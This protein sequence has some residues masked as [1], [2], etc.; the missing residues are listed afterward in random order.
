MVREETAFK[1]GEWQRLRNGDGNEGQ[2]LLIGSE[3]QPAKLD[4]KLPC[5]K[6]SI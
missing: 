3:A 4:Q 5:G 2:Q 1:T 6:N